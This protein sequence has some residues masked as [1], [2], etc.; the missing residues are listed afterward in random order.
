MKM[1]IYSVF[2]TACGA[3]QKPFFGN[4]DGEVMRSFIDIA[5]DAEH[6]I[7]QH[8]EDYSL[9]RLGTFDDQN[10][11]IQNEENSCLSTGLEAVAHSRNV[12]KSKIDNL[13]DSLAKS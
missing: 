3:Y 10:G 8:P 4:A 2:D 1:N 11:L 7:G 13:Q 6:A 9:M 12:D 5:T